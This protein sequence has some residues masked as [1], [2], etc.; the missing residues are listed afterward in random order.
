MTDAPLH[1]RGRVDGMGDLNEQGSYI[2]FAYFEPGCEHRFKVAAVEAF[3]IA[4]DILALGDGGG[5]DL[6]QSSLS[7]PSRDQSAV[8]LALENA[9]S[10]ALV[11]L[12]LMAGNSLLTDVQRE[13]ARAAHEAFFAIRPVWHYRPTNSSLTAGPCPGT[14]G[15]QLEPQD[16]WQTIDSAPKDGTQFW[17]V[18]S[19]R[20][21]QYQCHWDGVDFRVS[22]APSGYNLITTLTHWRLLPSP[23]SVPQLQPDSTGE[24]NG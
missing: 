21:W 22:A 5:E 24:K 1:L 20:Q 12:A 8:T 6:V 2:G 9:I 18:T 15:G 14:A 16:G 4:R 7:A 23:P 17:G 3:G 10:N 19:G 13:T 11:P